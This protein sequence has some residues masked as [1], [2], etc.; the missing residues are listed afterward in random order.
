M[1]RGS[2]PNTERPAV[3]STEAFESLVDC[4]LHFYNYVEYMGDPQYGE[5]L[6]WAPLHNFVEVGE[7][8]IQPIVRHYVEA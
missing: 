1:G 7:E 2:T 6:K 8:R 4:G 3:N 5:S